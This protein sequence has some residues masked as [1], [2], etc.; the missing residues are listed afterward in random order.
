MF[1]SRCTRSLSVRSCGISHLGDREIAL[2]RQVDLA[3]VLDVQFVE[4]RADLAP[5]AGFFGGVLD[6]RRAEP[7]EPVP[8]AE[9]EQLL[10]AFDVL[11]VAES[12]MSRLQLELGRFR[13]RDHDLGVDR[14][15]VLDELPGFLHGDSL[16]HCQAVRMH[17]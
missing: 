2:R 15:A 13:R 11:V 3:G 9:R 5:D 17:Q 14:H 4:L 7:L 1:V 10:P 8:P 6:E 12:R 16:W